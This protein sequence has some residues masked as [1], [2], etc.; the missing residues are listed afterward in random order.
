MWRL[1]HY[2]ADSMILYATW[3]WLIV[4]PW[5]YIIR[6]NIPLHYENLGF[7]LEKEEYHN[8]GRKVKIQFIFIFHPWRFH[9]CQRWC[10]HA[11]WT[12]CYLQC[13]AKLTFT[14]I[15]VVETCYHVSLVFCTLRLV[16]FASCYLVSDMLMLIVSLTGCVLF[17]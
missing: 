3:V 2:V 6:F 17:I 14:V 8:L 7:C 13:T 10:S 4:Y 1:S 5:M 15:G 12:V 16:Y 9:I 11:P